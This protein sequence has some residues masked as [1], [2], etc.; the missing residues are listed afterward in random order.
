MT[1]NRT[2]ILISL[3]LHGGAIAFVFALSSSIAQPTKPIEID[4]TLVEPAGPPLPEPPAAA[5]QMSP[6]PPA[7]RKKTLAAKM[8]FP[9]SVARRPAPAQAPLPRE[10]VPVFAS[11]NQTPPAPVQ[12]A[13]SQSAGGS[14]G[15]GSPSGSAQGTGGGGGVSIEQLGSRY[16]SEHFA[17][18][19]KI[20]EEN[21]VYPPRAQ[22]MGWSGNCVVEF[23]VQAN[24]HAKDIRVLRSTG[25]E[26]LDENVI[27]TIRKVDPFP[28]PPIPVKLTIPFAYKLG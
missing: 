7:P 8:E 12:Q 27:E 18:I 3:T 15:G 20:I 17:Y 19:K 24:G 5:P 1:P 21:L 26:L 23:V 25:Y 10:P 14:V 16:R 9:R 13:A 6:E 2:G 22:R 4:F 28:R 11:P